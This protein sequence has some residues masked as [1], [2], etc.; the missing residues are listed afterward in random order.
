MKRRSTLTGTLA[1]AGA[2]ALPEFAEAYD[3]MDAALH[4]SDA[5]DLPKRFHIGR[6]G[7]RTE[8]FRGGLTGKP[9]DQ[10]TAAINA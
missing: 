8:T 7:T 9:R 4:G 1:M 2:G 3:G 6:V 5:V 10:L